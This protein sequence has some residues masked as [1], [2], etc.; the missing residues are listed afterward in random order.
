M[1][2]NN[3]P[4]TIVFVNQ[5]AGYLMIDIVNAFGERYAERV[6]FTGK[7]NTRNRV[8]DEGVKIEKIKTYSRSSAIN[9]ILAWTI[10]FFQTLVKIRFKYR[11]AHLFLVSNPPLTTL[12]PLFCKNSFS[13]LIYDVYPDIIYQNNYFS[14]KALFIRF[15][16]KLNKK[17]Y[18]K[19][20]AIYTITDGMQQALKKYAGEV[21]VKVVP[22]WTDNEYLKPIEK[23]ENLFI[24]AQQL[25]GQFVV[26]YS[27]NIGQS[28]N[29]D[30]LVNL[31]ARFN[32]KNIS[33]VIVGQG[34]HKNQI[35]GL[36][37][38]K[39][40]N[41][42]IVLPWQNNEMFP[43]VLAA[44]DIAVVTLNEK[45]SQ[46][47]IPSK[48]Y[49]YLSVGAPILSVSGKH[50]DLEKVINTYQVGKNFQAG[51]ID[52]MYGFIN[53]LY[54]HP[55]QIESYRFNSLKASTYFTPL[56]ARQFL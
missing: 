7:L 12:L 1:S 45:A 19:A 49:N 14:R 31:A 41:N 20:R 18:P 2:K 26:L 15:W 54:S 13:F 32:N 36:I 28:Q 55:E 3:K 29:V 50:S 4:G 23:G 6:L 47:S 48:F 38:T 42:C 37:S 9:R 43:H 46:S 52:Q 34:T 27:G 44:A 11:S 40:V 39:G 25:Q 24:Q 17:I 21:P 5:S 22:I 51:E 10:G 16:E 8:L 33:F 35:D 56:N 53:S 30:V